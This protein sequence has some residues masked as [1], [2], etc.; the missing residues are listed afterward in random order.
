M[1][2]AIRSLCAVLAVLA[3]GYWWLRHELGPS[4]P[5]RAAAEFHSAGPFQV[6]IALDPVL[7]KVGKNRLTLIVRDQAGRPVAGAKVRA[8]AEMPAMGAMPAMQAPAEIEELE[9]GRYAGSFD[10]AMSGEWPLTLDIDSDAFGHGRILFEMATGRAGL[11]PAMLAQQPQAAAAPSG[12]IAV[13]VRRR[14]LIGVTTARVQ[15]Q[16]LRPAIRA[17][18][19]VTYDERRLTDVALKF[20]AWIGKLH[21]NYV[22]APVRRGEILLSVY[23]PELVSAQ[24]EY[25]DTLRRRKTGK[26]T[27][28]A[29][30]RRR[31]ARWNMGTA[32]IRALE[33]RGVGSDYVSIRAPASGTVIEKNIV[34]GTAVKAGDTLMRIADLTTVWVEAQVYEYEVSLVR[35]GMAAEITLPNLPGRIFEGR[36]SYIY[37]ALDGPTR[38]ARLRI[39]LDNP[40]GLLHPQAYAQVQLIADLGERLLVPDSAVIYAGATRV[41]FVDSGQ[42]YLEPRKVSVGHRAEN[43]IEV[44]EGLSEGEM[45]VTSGNFLIA[46]ESKLKAG[47]DQW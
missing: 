27:L 31:L 33:S 37:P 8:N 9:P 12:R 21:A 11:R 10:L 15:R 26:D 45:V 46:A 16:R 47:I 30:A 3:I 13:D 40:E 22:G 44:L 34:A 35:I 14:Q 6:N 5:D 17:A 1:T 38:T 32:E 28:S 4:A 25:L 2:T 20:D 18:G 24:E 42:G 29:A 36:V 7:P 23:S 43:A 19:Q 41:V 39:E